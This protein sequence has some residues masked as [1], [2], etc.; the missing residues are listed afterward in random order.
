MLQKSHVN[1]DVGTSESISSIVHGITLQKSHVNL[2]VGTI[3][4]NPRNTLPDAASK[5]PRQFRRGNRSSHKAY[6][7]CSVFHKISSKIAM[8]ASRVSD[9]HA[10]SARSL[11]ALYAL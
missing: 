1:L 6:S 2:D 7:I 8:F 9:L 10:P 4:T 3:T 11:P 5:E